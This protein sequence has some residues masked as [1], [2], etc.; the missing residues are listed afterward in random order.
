MLSLPIIRVGSSCET[1]C[2]SWPHSL[3]VFDCCYLDQS[4][5]EGRMPTVAISLW[6]RATA[7]QLLTYP[8]D[9]H[10]NDTLEETIQHTSVTAYRGRGACPAHQ[11]YACSNTNSI[12][13]VGKICLRNF[14][15]RRHAH[16]PCRDMNALV[17]TARAPL[18]NDGDQG[19]SARSRTRHPSG[20]SRGRREGARAAGGMGLALFSRGCNGHAGRSS[21]GHGWCRSY[22]WW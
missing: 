15:K 22:P 14:G 20:R 6:D 5:D 21:H 13:S 19:A 12:S 18:P 1:V 7:E 2:T 9:G 4:A 16:G 17:C 10:E 3:N 11:T 8:N